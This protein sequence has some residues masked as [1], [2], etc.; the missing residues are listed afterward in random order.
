[1][2]MAM[3]TLGVSHFLG[4]KLK[5][6]PSLVEQVTKIIAD[7]NL[8]GQTSW[9][10]IGSNWVEKLGFK[11]EMPDKLH[12]LGEFND[13]NIYFD[14]FFPADELLVGYNLKSRS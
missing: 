2:L 11:N 12:R 13:I 1:M 8:T 7:N 14:P 9:L 5:A 4:V 3:G 10:L 6:E